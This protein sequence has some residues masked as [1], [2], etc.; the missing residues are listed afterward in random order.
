MPARRFAVALAAVGLAALALRVAFTLVVDPEVPEVGD[1][2]AYHHLAN[3]L[4][5]G[6]GYVRPFDRLFF[7]EIRPTAEYPPLFPATV[8]VSSLVGVRSVTGHRMV[9]CVIGA[10]GVVVIGL[11]GRRVAGAGVGVAAAG[12]AAVYPMLLL[13][14]ATLTPEGLFVLLVSATLLAC[15]HAAERPTPWRFGAVGVL[16]GLAALTRAE[17]ALLVVL[18]AV[19]LALSRRFA[20]ERADRLR[21]AGAALAGTALV[22]LPWTARNTARFDQVVP[23]S[24]NVG[25]ALDGANCDPTYHGPTTGFWLYTD[26]GECFDGFAQDELERLDEAAVAAQHRDEGLR[27]ARAHAGRLPAVGAVRL[28][29]TWG[30]WSPASQ[31]ALESLEGRPLRWQRAGTAMYWGLAPLAVAGVVVLRRRGIRTWPLLATVVSVCVTTLATYGNQRFRA[32]AEPA[33]LVLAAVAVV[34]VIHAASGRRRGSTCRT[35]ATPDPAAPAPR[36]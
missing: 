26:G 3:Q 28:L 9:T 25:S 36:G 30:V 2:M 21:W 1:A 5:D 14:D 19:P 16:A 22:V 23:I 24:N 29:R 8:A 7:D 33:L 18:V 17:A 6:D 35:A 27:Y 15:Y 34:A 20:A 13:T 4:A 12:L 11:L 31:T 32:A 10:A